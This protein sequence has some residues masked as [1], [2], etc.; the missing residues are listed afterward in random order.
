MILYLIEAEKQRT[1]TERIDRLHNLQISSKNMTVLM[2]NEQKVNWTK[3][4]KMV[5]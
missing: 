3:K 2:G 4:Y 5:C 1:T